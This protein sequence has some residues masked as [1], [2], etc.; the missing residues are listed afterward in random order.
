MKGGGGWGKRR[1]RKRRERE[2]GWEKRRGKRRRE[3][4]GG[5]REDKREGR[6]GIG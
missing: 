5:E 6:E 3:G 2:G 1:S 4:R